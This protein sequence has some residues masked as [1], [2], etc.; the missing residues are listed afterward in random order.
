MKALYQT[1]RLVG[2]GLLV[3]TILGL[4]AC[5]VLSNGRAAPH[6]Y[7]TFGVLGAVVGVLGS[8]VGGAIIVIMR[9]TSRFPTRGDGNQ[10]HRAPHS[11]RRDAG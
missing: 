7:L 3:G 2:F 9:P 6:F 10:N 5:A 4:L 1:L 8:V 11:E